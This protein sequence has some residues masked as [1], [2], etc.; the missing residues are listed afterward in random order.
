MQNR[1]LKMFKKISILLIFSSLFL[2]MGCSPKGGNPDTPLPDVDTPD[3]TLPDIT[4]D[5]IYDLQGF[6]TLGEGTTGGE[7][8]DV[9]YVST[10][11]ELQNEIKKGGPRI[12]YVNGKITPDNSVGL[13]EI[14]IKNVSKISIIGVGTEGE[15]EG[16]GIKISNANNIIIKNLKIHHV[17]LGN[18]DCITIEGPAKNIWIDHCEL[19]NEFREDLDKD[20]YD[21]LLDINGRV[22]Y[23]T[24]SWC[25][26][27]DSWKTS[28]IGSSDN[29]NYNRTITYH[30]NLF[31]NCNSRVPS[32]R[33]GEGHIF[34]NYYENIES[35][36]INSRMGAKIRVEYN[37][38]ENVK[39]P[40]CSLDSPEFGYWHM[41]GNIFKDCSGVPG[42]STC[43]YNPP[44]TYSVN[45]AVKAKE[46]V[47]NY[48]GVGKI[49]P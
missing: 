25:Y 31:K 47:S 12:I 6:A 28:L 9:V 41:V 42:S 5:I 37:Y 4:E 19:F 22:D 7:G 23:V 1:S 18:K 44:Y 49:S 43:I 36:G 13:N 39:R 46:Y 29:D 27:H 2:I 33:F 45:T 20:Y 14:Y 24:V 3:V 16:I 10:G 26:F 48:V 38:F 34:N 17:L 21:G 11:S 32:F 30:H 8:G 15:L 40:I 35:S